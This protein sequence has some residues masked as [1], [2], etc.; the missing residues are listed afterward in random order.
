V[1]YLDEKFIAV[2]EKVEQKTKESLER[3]KSMHEK[4][5]EGLITMNDII[6]GISEENKVKFS[7][8]QAETAHL[9]ESLTQAM[10]S[11]AKS[12]EHEIARQKE[13]I[14]AIARHHIAHK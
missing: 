4:V 3:E 10:E 7:K 12:L 2:K 13:D 14:K 1:K 9:L 6:K 5:Q 11:T 8:V